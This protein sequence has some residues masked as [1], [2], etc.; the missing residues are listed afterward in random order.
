VELI[1][2]VARLQVQRARLKPGPAGERV[3]DPSPLLEVDALEVGPRG[4]VG[5]RPEGRVVD[6]HHADH[7]DTRNRRLANGLS[8][9]PR[10]H[11]ER[12]RARYGPHL[13]DGLAG[14]S[15]LLAGGPLGEADLAGDLLLEVDEGLLPVDG[16]VAAPPCV[17]FARFALG[18]EVGDTGPEVLAALDDLDRGVRGFYL[19]PQATGVVRRGA[20][21][22]RPI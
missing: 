2:T 3:Y 15:L 14:E 13:A 1:A 9:L 4:V 20:R 11:Y 22:L 17:E 10:A 5:L 21:L 19:Q 12:L 6:V 18:R 16:A 7:P 8:V